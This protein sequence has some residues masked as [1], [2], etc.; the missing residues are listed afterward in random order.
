MTIIPLVAL[1]VY[2]KSSEYKDN[3]YRI[4]N[5]KLQYSCA[6]RIMGENMAHY[7]RGHYR[8][9]GAYVKGHARSS[10]GSGADAAAIA[11]L[12]AAVVAIIIGAVQLITFIVKKM[13][14]KFGI[15][16]TVIAFASGFGI[17]LILI[18]IGTGFPWYVLTPVAVIAGVPYLIKLVRESKKE[19]ELEIESK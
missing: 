19:P 9:N 15:Q 10:R 1:V 16:D 2:V 12:I 11:A 6:T 4:E 18:V 5:K 13:T 8:K 7:V 14:E 3:K 17:L